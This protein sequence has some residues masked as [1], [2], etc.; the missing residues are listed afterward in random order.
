M[1]AAPLFCSRLTWVQ[2][3]HT[4]RPTTAETAA[5]AHFPYRGDLFFIF[6]VLY[7]T[8]L[9]LPPLRFL[10]VGGCW[11]RTQDSCHFGIGCQTRLDLILIHFPLSYSYFSLYNRNVSGE[12]PKQTT[13]K[14]SWCSYL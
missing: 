2:H 13:T 7:S 5:I 3:S 4:P 9:H 1:E 14:K 6:S 11:D 8:L 10:C 12:D